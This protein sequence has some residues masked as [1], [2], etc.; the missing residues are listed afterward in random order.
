MQLQINGEKHTIPVDWQRESLLEVLR[1]TGLG[2]LT[3]YSQTRTDFLTL[4][5]ANIQ[6]A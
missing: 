2:L 4:R 5:Q 6:Q 3:K 1:D